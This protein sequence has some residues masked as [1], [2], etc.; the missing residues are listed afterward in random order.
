MDPRAP[1]GSGE[2]G[3]EHSCNL[4]KPR[5]PSVCLPGTAEPDAGGD[6]ACVLVGLRG[7]RPRQG[8]ELPTAWEVS[9]QLRRPSEVWL[10]PRHCMF[11]MFHLIFSACFNL[12]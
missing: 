4:D 10:C 12:E 11:G 8:L 2:A 1:M 9:P 7:V 5:P 6:G 3:G